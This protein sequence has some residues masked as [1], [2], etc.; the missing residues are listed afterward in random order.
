MHDRMGNV[1]MG[2]HGSLGL[3]RRAGGIKNDGNVLFMY[4]NG[5]RTRRIG[6]EIFEWARSFGDT[7]NGE[8]MLDALRLRQ[9]LAQVVLM[10]QDLG[11]GVIEHIGV[12]ASAREH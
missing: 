8:A 4:R 11:A 6:Q 10:N 5:R 2:E 9:T 3:P 1:H 7:A 12:L